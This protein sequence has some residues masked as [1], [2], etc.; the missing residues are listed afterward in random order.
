MVAVEILGPAVAGA[1]VLVLDAA[2]ALDVV[3]LDELLELPHPARASATPITS[4]V[5]NLVI[6]ASYRA[7]LPFGYA[8][9]ITVASMLAGP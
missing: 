2:G 6:E 9:K 4:S 1:A 8:S 3:L 5:A 7:G